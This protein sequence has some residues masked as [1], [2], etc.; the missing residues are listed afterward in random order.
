MKT[1]PPGPSDEAQDA[2]CG[3]EKRLRTSA[4]DILLD[5]KEQRPARFE[6]MWCA[7]NRRRL[8]VAARSFTGP[9]TG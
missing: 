3:S 7:V 4:R 6:P 2:R 9:S 5:E 1:P 8:I